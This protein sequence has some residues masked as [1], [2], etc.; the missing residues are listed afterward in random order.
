[1]KMKILMLALAVLFCI[2]FP[3]DI[4][5]ALLWFFGIAVIGSVVFLLTDYL[6]G[7]LG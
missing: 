1:M 2:V 3:S 4:P 6:D 5:A 7:W